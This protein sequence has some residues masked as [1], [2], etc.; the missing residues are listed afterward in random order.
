MQKALK[1]EQDY[2]KWQILARV[3]GQRVE[4]LKRVQ[5][6]QTSNKVEIGVERL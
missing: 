6:Q 1:K 5:Q 3:K 2:R 4:N